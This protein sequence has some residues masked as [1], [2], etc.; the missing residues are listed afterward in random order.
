[1]AD[2][3]RPTDKTDGKELSRFFEETKLLVSNIGYRD[4]NDRRISLEL[5][6]K[7]EIYLGGLHVLLNNEIINAQTRGLL[8]SSLEH[9][10]IL[11][12]EIQR[13]CFIVQFRSTPIQF[14]IAFID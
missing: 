5:A 7:V 2:A 4:I 14:K 10:L 6:H 13:D 12:Q 8:Q 1:M 9:L 11:F 3:D